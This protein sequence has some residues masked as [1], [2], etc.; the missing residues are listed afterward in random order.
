MQHVRRIGVGAKSLWVRRVARGGIEI[1]HQ[2]EGFA[3]PNPFVHRAADAL[4]ILR[5]RR[6]ATVGRDGATDDLHVK[7]IR[8][9]NDLFISGYQDLR[10]DVAPTSSDVVD[11]LKD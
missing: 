1:H 3:G 9:L 5:V 8:R 4:A 11:A 7:L 6:G 10:G 2:I